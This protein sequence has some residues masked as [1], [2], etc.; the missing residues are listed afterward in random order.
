MKPTT[1]KKKPA[2]ARQTIAKNRRAS[3]DFELGEKFTAGIALHGPEV[4]SL[5]AGRVAVDQAYARLEGDEIWLVD[6]HIPE[7]LA[8]SWTNHITKRPR[9]LLLHRREI[10]KLRGSLTAGGETL[11]PLELFFDERGLAKVTLA[12]ARG[13]KKHDKRAALAKKSAQ[14]EMVRALR[15]E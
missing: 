2:Q 10:E 9:K 4:K 6:L 7:Y 13:K 3:F 8:A 5:R 12:L 1:E 11:V 14:S 15:R